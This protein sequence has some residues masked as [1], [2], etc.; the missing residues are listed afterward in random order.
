MADTIIHPGGPPTFEM[1]DQAVAH[2]ESVGGR[3]LP[4]HLKATLR[5]ECVD[6]G[7]TGGLAVPNH[8]VDRINTYESGY[9]KQGAQGV[10]DRIA[11]EY[12]HSFPSA[13]HRMNLRS[14]VADIIDHEYHPGMSPEHVEQAVQDYHK[15]VVRGQ[16]NPTQYLKERL[17]GQGTA[18]LPFTTAEVETLKSGRAY[19]PSVT[20]ITKDNY[21]SFLSGHRNA[22]KASGTLPATGVGAHIDGAHD[23][24]KDALKKHFAAGKPGMSLDQVQALMHEHTE[25]LHNM[26]RGVVKFKDP[27]GLTKHLEGRVSGKR[28]SILQEPKIQTRQVMFEEVGKLEPTKITQATRK[29]VAI[30]QIL[31]KH[32]ATGTLVDAHGVPLTQEKMSEVVGHLAQQE[33]GH[34]ELMA[35]HTGHGMPPL[36]GDNLSRATH[37]HGQLESVIKKPVLAPLGTAPVATPLPTTGNK[38]LDRAGTALEAAN[39]ERETHNIAFEEQKRAAQQMAAEV[40]QKR[41]KVVAADAKLKGLTTPGADPKALLDAQK[42]AAASQKELLAAKTKLNTQAKVVAEQKQALNTYTRRAEQAEHGLQ[43]V[44]HELAPDVVAKPKPR[45]LDIGKDGAR[46]T[47]DRVAD[48][49]TALDKRRYDLEDAQSKVAKTEKAVAKVDIGNPGS[50]IDKATT[51]LTAAQQTHGRATQHLE[52]LRTQR[53]ALAQKAGNKKLPVA[54]R[55]QASS[56][57][58]THDQAIKDAIAAQKKTQAGLVTATATH[59]TAMQPLKKATVAHDTAHQATAN[60]K[61]S[62]TPTSENRVIKQAAADKALKAEQAAAAKLARQEQKAAQA[63]VRTEQRAAQQLARQTARANKPPGL[64]SRL[65]SDNS[66]MSG[67]SRG[68]VQTEKAIVNATV[69]AEKQAPSLMRRMLSGGAHG[70]T[71]VAG[72]ATGFVGNTMKVALIGGAGIAALSLLSNLSAARP[73]PLPRRLNDDLDSNTNPMVFGANPNVGVG[74]VAVPQMNQQTQMGSWVSRL[75]SLDE[76]IAMGGNPPMPTR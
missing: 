19:F 38:K 55:M 21:E 7:R 42:E 27:D 72:T 33:A 37:G 9:R 20:T 4:D 5:G 39:V 49:H 73:I 15:A 29:Q 10:V 45:P 3:T 62:N 63:L 68:A 36:T 32:I 52:D 6:M 17:R 61:Y 13:D 35:S 31:N 65:W 43:Q 47:N 24:M 23:H 54:D 74:A 58:K 25:V 16:P 53:Q 56:T 40:E 30:K 76:T 70:A 59:E 75:P 66:T 12:P 2:Y 44:Q 60:G 11:G 71:A 50:G 18:Q 67:M 46:T 48:K 41:Q 26:D 64:L 1:V 57:L 14:K 34:L 51:D 8:F 28:T 69:Q 22:L